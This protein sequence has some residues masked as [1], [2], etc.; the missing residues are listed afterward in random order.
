MQASTGKL[1]RIEQGQLHVAPSA[2]ANHWQCYKTNRNPPAPGQAGSAL[3]GLSLEG[4]VTMTN[5]GK[6]ITYYRVDPANLE[7]W[8]IEH[9]YC[10]AEQIQ[11]ALASKQPQRS[12]TSALA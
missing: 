9:G 1:V 8:A 10:S 11:K 6:E 2:L 3:R 5:G 4:T 12:I 7:T